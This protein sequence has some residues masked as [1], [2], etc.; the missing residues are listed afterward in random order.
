MKLCIKEE[1]ISPEKLKLEENEI[2]CR[3]LDIV[4]SMDSD[5]IH[6][7]WTYMLENEYVDAE[8]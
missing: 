6:D 3:I 2:R 1:D 5:G 4:K 8:E 7:L